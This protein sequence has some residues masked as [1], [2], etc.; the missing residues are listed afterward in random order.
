MKS[1]VVKLTSRGNY[2]LDRRG[3]L[4]F[5]GRKADIFDDAE[6][7]RIRIIQLEECGTKYSCTYD[8][9]IVRAEVPCL[10]YVETSGDKPNYCVRIADGGAVIVELEDSR[11]PLYDYGNGLEPARLEVSLTSMRYLYQTYTKGKIINRTTKKWQ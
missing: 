1:V 5:V 4:N 6:N 10:I 7:G 11:L 3:S 2:K 8:K 9:A